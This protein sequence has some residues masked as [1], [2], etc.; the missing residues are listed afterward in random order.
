[1]STTQHPAASARQ[2]LEE[3]KFWN[4]FA[5]RQIHLFG[6]ESHEAQRAVNLALCAWRDLTPDARDAWKAEMVSRES[7]A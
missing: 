5:N 1:M 6:V 7:A 4:D 2:Q 3:L